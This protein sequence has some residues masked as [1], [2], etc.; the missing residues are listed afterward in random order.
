MQI[1]P[2]TYAAR[3]RKTSNNFCTYWGGDM[4]NTN[5]ENYILEEIKNL[6]QRSSICDIAWC[7]HWIHYLTP[8]DQYVLKLATETNAT[9]YKPLILDDR[10]VS[11]WK[12]S[13]PEFFMSIELYY[14]FLYTHT[15][16]NS[17]PILYTSICYY[18]DSDC[19]DR[20]H[21]STCSPVKMDDE[22]KIVKVANIEIKDQFLL[23]MDGILN[24]A[25]LS[26]KTPLFILKAL[27]NLN[28]TIQNI[29]STFSE[30]KVLYCDEGLVKG[31]SFNYYPGVGFGKCVE[32]KYKHLCISLYNLLK[33]N[34]GY[35]L[36]CSEIKKH[37]MYTFITAIQ[38][39]LCYGQS[40]RTDI[41]NFWEKHCNNIVCI[42]PIIIYFAF[43]SKVNRVRR[44]S[45]ERIFNHPIKVHKIPYGMDTL[46]NATQ[47]LI[48]LLIK[49]P[50][51]ILTD[52]LKGFYELCLQEKKKNEKKT[53]DEA[54]LKMTTCGVEDIFNFEYKK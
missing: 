5:N 11:S 37:L 42:L 17:F 52:D 19:P 40:K 22:N 4:S 24:L 27:I 31:V 8:A 33:N 18:P 9:S 1:I 16:S 28:Q 34:E 45:I 13:Y 44:R 48:K 51:V 6:F 38:T 53:N 7:D 46:I 26:N 20:P 36:S 25:K 41:I 47:K 10:I 43:Y 35:F 15:S 30:V 29:R 23:Y 21:A 54:I 50:Q 3:A 12:K 32:F 2:I 49:E 39:I 14:Y